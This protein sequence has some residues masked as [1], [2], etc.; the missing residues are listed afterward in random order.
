MD[1]D[2]GAVAAISVCIV[3]I[4]QLVKVA[5]GK[6]MK[7]RPG[8]LLTLLVGAAIC[9]CYFAFGAHWSRICTVLLAIS[10]AGIFYDTIYSAFKKVF[11]GMGKAGAE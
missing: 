6:E 10:G 3:G 9:A 7:G 8:L 1:I 4:T 2:Y 5:I 11:E